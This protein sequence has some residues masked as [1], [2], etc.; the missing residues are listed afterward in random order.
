ML[1]FVLTGCI[2][3]SGFSIA[4]VSCKR[5]RTIKPAVLGNMGTL[6]LPR[7]TARIASHSISSILYRSKR[8]THCS[9]S[10][11]PRK[12]SITQIKGENPV[13]SFHSRTHSP[14][15]AKTPPAKRN[16]ESY[17]D[18]VNPRS[19]VFTAACLYE[20]PIG[21]F[22]AVDSHL[23]FCVNVAVRWSVLISD[24]SLCLRF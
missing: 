17:G 11:F 15:F 6:S 12:L 24:L 7:T 19:Q 21:G 18:E 2:I 9:L 4:S 8:L 22:M 1:T 23:I 16:E 13:R 14:F 20:T 10:F 5:V 3:K